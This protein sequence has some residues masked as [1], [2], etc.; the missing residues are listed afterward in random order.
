MRRFMPEAWPLPLLDRFNR[1]Y[2]TSGRLTVQVCAACGIAQHP[3]NDIC[4]HCQHME[5]EYREAKGTGT[6]YSYTVIHHAVNEMLNQSIPYAAVL[7]QLDDYPR[8]KITGNVVN[9]EPSRVR[10]GL[11][12]RVTWEEIPDELQGETLR[13]PQ[14]E[15]VG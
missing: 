14:W 10:I 12:V 8:V 9:L 2:F 15:V 7:V 5:F 6:V 4:I 13:L 3:P 11:P 1:E